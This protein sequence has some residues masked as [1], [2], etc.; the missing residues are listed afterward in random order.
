M[1]DPGG[2][3]RPRD[4]SRQRQDRAA[5]RRGKVRV[6]SLEAIGKRIRRLRRE[7]ERHDRLYYE[8]ADPVIT[9]R[10]YDALFRELRELEEEYPE[11]RSSDSPTNRVG[12]AP[13]EGFEQLPHRTPMLSLDNTYSP[14]ELIEFDE[15]VR[16]LTGL[17]KV[18][19]TAEM[20]L[21]GVAV[22]LTYEDGVLQ[23]A[24]SRGNGWVGDDITRNIRTVHSIPLRLEK[25]VVP[26]GILDVRGEVYLTYEGLEAMN[27]AQEGAGEKPFAN[28]RNAAAGSLKLLDSSLVA[29]RPLRCFVFQV[30]E[31]ER[32]GLATQWETLRFLRSAGFP[33]SDDSKLCDGIDEAVKACLF[34]Q[35]SRADLPYATDGAVIKVNDLSLYGDLGATARSPRWGIA[36]KFPAERKRTVLKEIVAQVGRTGAVTPVAI[37]EPVELAGTTVRRATLH[38]EEEIARRDIRLGDT[39]WIEKSGEIIPR[40]LGV[41]EEKRPEETAPYTLPSDCPVCASPL[42]RSDDE[43]AVRCENPSCPAQVRGRIVHFAARNAMDIEGL[44]VKAVDAIVSGGLASDIAGLYHLDGERLAALE[45]FGEKSAKNLLA[46]VEESKGRS[47]ARFL[48]GLGIRRVGRTVAAV[49]ASHFGS[50]DRLRSAG[51]EELADIDDVGPVIARSVVRFFRSD[52]GSRLIDRLL[53]AG[54][55]PP[56]EEKTRREAEGAVAGKRFVLTGKLPTLKR[57][58]ARGII[59]GAGGIVVSSVS[60]KTDFVVAGKSSGSKRKKAEELG[61][62]VIDEEELLRMTGGGE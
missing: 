26:P 4:A 39:V 12:G 16:K 18:V 44:G 43:V 27:R 51:E 1:E 46:S 61:V 41:V 25:G 7:I 13:L 42:V 17:E 59:E 11:L 56:V 40:I 19:Y 37:V 55:S 22:A 9:D 20:K 53:E 54:V 35:Q 48:F 36:Y 2:G 14:E 49:L 57:N 33:V 23:R 52:E 21:D 28:P 32:F 5:G 24:L 31:P 60:G 62:P 58:E 15:R 10:E 45:R 38:N 47:L 3:A 8:K 6:E 29:K 50:L 34:F 30:V